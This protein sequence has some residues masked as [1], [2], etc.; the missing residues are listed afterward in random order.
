MR[1]AVLVAACI[2]A[3]SGCA[4]TVKPAPTAPV[5]LIDPFADDPVSFLVSVRRITPGEVAIVQ[6]CV[7]SDGTIASTHLMESSGDARFDSMAVGWAR[8]IKLRSATQDSA[9]MAPCGSVRV[10]SRLPA[11][12]KVLARPSTSLG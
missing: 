4:A 9:P 8:M 5:Q 10:E 6:V 1:T 3:I 7:A 11:D 12:P 2:A